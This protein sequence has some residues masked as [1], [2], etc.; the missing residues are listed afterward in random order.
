MQLQGLRARVRKRFKCT[1]N[2]DH[3]Q[4]VAANL[5]GRNFEADRPNQKWVG[6]TTELI[7]SNGKLLLAVILDL[8]SK[9]V[10][11]WSLSPVN[12]RHLTLAAEIPGRFIA[13]A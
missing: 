5:L 2:S 13:L 7:T 4:P 10:V 6:D 11:G 12:D 3:D 9:Y 1:T 8:F